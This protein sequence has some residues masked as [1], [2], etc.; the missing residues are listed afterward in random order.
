MEKT[1][2]GFRLLTGAWAAATAMIFV[3]LDFSAVSGT[4]ALLACLL[5]VLRMRK[6]KK[7]WTPAAVR[8]CHII[9]SVGVLMGTALAALEIFELV[10]TY[11][12]VYDYAGILLVLFVWWLAEKIVLAGIAAVRRMRGKGRKP[13]RAKPFRPVRHAREGGLTG[14]ALKHSEGMN[15]TARAEEPIEGKWRCPVC[16]T[17]NPMEADTC[18]VCTANRPG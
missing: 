8:S 12:T 7:L 15:E 6:G 13:E 1:A 9:R 17:L 4:S 3:A 11:I 14:T 10:E 5:V 2:S 18:P 16:E